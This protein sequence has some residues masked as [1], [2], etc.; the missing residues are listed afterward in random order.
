MKQTIALLLV[1][2]TS[3]VAYSQ[4]RQEPGKSIGSVTVQGNLIVMELN[5]GVWGK[6]NMFDLARRTLRFT[7]DAGGYRAENLPLQWDPEFGKEASEP[8]QSFT[9][10]TFPFSGKTWNSLSLGINGS[11][12]FGPPANVPGGGGGGQRGGGGSSESFRQLRTPSLRPII[13]R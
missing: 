13:R 8:Q 10:F 11:I 4:N 6:S 5:E 2:L 1:A 9:N 7:P 3:I 12:S